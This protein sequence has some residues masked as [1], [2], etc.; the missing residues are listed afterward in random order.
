MSCVS[1]GRCFVLGFV[2]KH[3]SAESSLSRPLK[4][5]SEVTPDLMKSLVLSART[6]SAHL[7]SAGQTAHSPHVPFVHHSAA[8]RR[9]HNFRTLYEGIS[10][11]LQDA[12]KPENLF[13]AQLLC[14]GFEDRVTCRVCS[15]S[16]PFP[17]PITDFTS[18]Y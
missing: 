8:L 3:R 13:K 1:V 18:S 14:F 11:I 16:A 10:I 2:V 9:R 17:F 7:V 5:S 6:V 4:Q 12:I 15:L